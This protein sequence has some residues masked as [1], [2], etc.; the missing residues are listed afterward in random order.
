MKQLPEHSSSGKIVNEAASAHHP[1]ADGGGRLWGAGMIMRVIAAAALILLVAW[2]THLIV[3]ESPV[4][5]VWAND[6]EDKVTQEELRAEDDT[7]SL[8]NS[9]WD[10]NS[11]TL[12]GARNEVV[13]FNLILEAANRQASDVSVRFPSLVGP[14]GYEIKGD[15][16]SGTKKVF[17]WIDRDIELFYVRYLQVRGL[18]HLSYDVRNERHVP[19]RFRLPQTKGGAYRGTWEDR[20]DHD[21]H[22]PDIAVP[23]ELVPHFDIDVRRSQSVWADVYI[24]KDAP[25]GIYYGELV[26]AVADVPAYKVPVTLSVH[27]FTLPDRPTSNTM[28]ATGFTQVAKRYIGAFPR[29]GTKGEELV[30]LVMDRQMMLAHRHKISLIDDN[31]GAGG[32]RRDEPRPEWLPRLSGFLF[33][34][35]NG[36]KG[37]GVGVGN[38]VF[39]IGIY[40]IWQRLWHNPNRSA[41][42]KRANGWEDWFAANAPHVERILYLSDESDDFARTEQWAKWLRTNPGSGKALRSF[43][44]VQL[45][46]ADRRIPSLDIPASRVGHGKPE[47]WQDALDR[48][49]EDPR[50]SFYFYNGFRP[51]SGS[52]AI[53]DDGVALREL[54]WGQYKLGIARWFAWESTYYQDIEHRRPP[55]NVFND[56][57]TFGAKTRANLVIGQSGKNSTNGEG[58]LFYPGTDAVYPAESY[59]LAGPMASLRLKY[60]RRGIQDV[61]YIA[62]AAAVDPERT[63]AIVDRMVP[64]ALW[65]NGDDG[66]TSWKKVSV[67]WS[68]DP[69]A[70]EHARAELA[71]IIEGNGATPPIR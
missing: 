4:S 49:N 7:A 38:D 43:A 22:Y 40:G 33:T 23:M 58:V 14:E 29:E 61:D 37:P 26:V 41:F 17:D 66:D 25:S 53:E 18:S 3:N 57:Q 42:W 35:G 12:F 28:L 11:V 1:Q 21:R 44:T 71:A 52:F 67:S 27:P 15:Y 5:A 36:Y 47:A 8:R 50:K 63:Q 24:P 13:N 54:P 19:E 70:W 64:K 6:G 9:V 32:W 34:E 59:G 56:A 46:D 55:T 62:L 45:P 10:G 65:E 60:W 69:D 20:P 16:V 30:K 39:C 31:G 68:A 51:G 2:R 48:L